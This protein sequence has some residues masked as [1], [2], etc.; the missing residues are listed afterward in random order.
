MLLRLRPLCTL[1]LRPFS[2]FF[3]GRMALPDRAA[4]PTQ[5]RPLQ[6]QITELLRKTPA[7]PAESDV[8]AV[9]VPDSNLLQGGAVAADVFNRLAGHTFD[10]VI[11][12]SPSHTGAF[13]RL[14]ICSVDTYHTPL[15]ILDVD[16]QVRNELCD[17]D[18]DIFL[19]DRGHFQNQGI[20]VQLPFL[21]TLLPPFSV[22]PIVMG[23]ETPGL[24]RELGHAVGEVMYSRRTLVVAS[25]DVLEAD[26]EHLERFKTLFEASEVDSL[27]ALLNSERVHMI[28]KGAVLAT[29]IAARHRKA[30]HFDIVRLEPPQ[31]GNPGFVGAVLSRG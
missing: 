27:M 31:D 22:V 23:D 20:D 21:Q 15:G 12:I 28:G 1:G 19:D 18:D 29:L 11:L 6:N 16:D 10:T 17:E 9:I 8:L 14:T 2:S 26:A 3:R 7:A 5:P 13:R 4:Y 30:N 25:A 24:C